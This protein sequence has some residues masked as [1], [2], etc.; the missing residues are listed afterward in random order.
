[1]SRAGK[2]VAQIVIAFAKFLEERWSLVRAATDWLKESVVQT[3]CKKLQKCYE[4]HE[5]I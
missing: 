4:I 3:A 2:S 1:M 5:P